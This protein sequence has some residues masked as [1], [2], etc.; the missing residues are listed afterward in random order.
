MIII[1]LIFFFS[2]PQKL[3]ILNLDKFHFYIIIESNNEMLLI[4]PIIRFLF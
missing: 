3:I 4:V 1:R 2:E